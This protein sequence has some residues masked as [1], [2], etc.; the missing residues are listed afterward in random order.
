M[1]GSRWCGSTLAA[2]TPQLSL[3]LRIVQFREGTLR[4]NVEFASWVAGIV[5]VLWAVYTY[6]W[7]HE[8]AQSAQQLPQ[9]SA[10]TSQSQALTVPV[11]APTSLAAASPIDSERL[12]PLIVLGATRASVEELFGTPTFDDG[13]SPG[14][15]RNLL[16]VFPK[17]FLQGIFSADG[18]LLLY[19]VTTRSEH[20]RP[21]VPKHGRR[22]LEA[23][24]QTYGDA[25]VVY[26]G[27]TSKYFEY[28]E[29]IRGTNAQNFKD[30]YLGYCPSG[31]GGLPTMPIVD[32]NE[33]AMDRRA[34]A[35]FRHGNRPNCFGVGEILS[36]NVDLVMH[37]R[38]GLNYFLGR[39][40]PR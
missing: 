10:A 19:S 25:E 20:F 30:I 32:V 18:R 2:H 7:P 4:K 11:L 28:L 8:S 39:D 29:V 3:R 24:Y 40:L 34:L 27:A 31:G 14:G 36:N 26:A 12:L 37:Y 9:P 15:E 16:F 22:L 6:F 33:V 1:P 17:F 35:E 23:T 38:L 5:G 13:G 21:E